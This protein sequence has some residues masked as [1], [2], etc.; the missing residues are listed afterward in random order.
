MSALPSTAALDG[1]AAAPLRGL[2]PAARSVLALLQRLRGDRL[3]LV[4]PDGRALHFGEHA[5]GEQAP[6]Q[7]RVLDWRAFGDT[8]RRGDIGFG[9]G[10]FEQRWTTSDLPR[11]LRLLL[12][13]RDSLQRALYGSAWGTL[14]LRLRHLLRGNSRRGSRLNIHAHYDIG[15]AFYASWLE[16]GM[17][18]S[19]ALFESGARDLDQAQ[20]AKLQRVLRQ[21]D[22]RPGSRVLEI[23]CGWGGFAE[24]A[25]AGGMRVDG[26]T[27]SSEQLQW[28]RERLRLAGLDERA[29]L[30]LLDYRDVARLAPPGGYDAIASIEMFEAVGERYWKGYFRVLA[31]NLRPGGRACVQSITID[32]ALFEAY[33]RG[34]DF[35]QQYVF[36]GGMLPSRAA[37]RRL[38]AAAGLEVVDEFAFGRDYARTL[39]LWRQRFVQASQELSAQG[40]DRR[41]R[42]L[43]E[44]Y[45]AYCEAGFAQ[46]STDVVQFTLRKREGA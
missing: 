11:L 37:F 24:A 5:A 20:Q 44:F 18:Y 3:E 1:A 22:A 32:D 17:N 41:F 35:I 4:L 39:E 13:N 2:P 15:N 7:L 46:G 10:Y 8:L 16:P 34:T 6:L 27:L 28:G 23:G 36:P 26:I 9:E 42:L 45:L 33:R 12:L 38:A 19:S 30:H 14:L 21:L 40:F 29:R 43:W 31:D 25:A